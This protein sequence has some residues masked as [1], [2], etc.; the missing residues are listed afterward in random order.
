[1]DKK[2]KKKSVGQVSSFELNVV[3][4][5]FLLIVGIDSSPRNRRF[6]K[7]SGHFKRILQKLETNETEME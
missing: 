3:Q 6:E 2:E 7:N 1:M 5:I 4:L